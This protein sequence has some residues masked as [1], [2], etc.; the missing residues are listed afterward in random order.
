MFQA[1]RTLANNDIGGNAPSNAGFYDRVIKLGREINNEVKWDIVSLLLVANPPEEFNY[2]ADVKYLYYKEK[3]LLG[4]IAYNLGRIAQE[5]TPLF[6]HV[7][8]APELRRTK[9]AYKFLYDT[10][11]DMKLKY[12]IIVAHI[13][14]DR[15]YMVRFALKVGFV[16]YSEAKDSKYYYLDLEKIR[17]D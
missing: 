9:I 17:G 5:E 14:N 7:I 11:R 2:K 15:E 6:I 12:K 13:P 1:E 4:I 3:K 16:M 10:F 8:L